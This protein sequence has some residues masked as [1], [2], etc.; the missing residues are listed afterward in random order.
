[1]KKYSILCSKRPKKVLS[2]Q[3]FKKASH[4]F[5]MQDEH[6]NKCAFPSLKVVMNNHIMNIRHVAP[7]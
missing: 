2:P 3:S 7:R 6:D 5:T 4:L 1:M